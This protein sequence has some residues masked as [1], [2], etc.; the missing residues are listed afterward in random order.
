[1]WI[2]GLNAERFPPRREPDPLLPFALQRK[3]RLPGTRSAKP[4]PSTTGAG[5]RRCSGSPPRFA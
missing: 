4:T 1:M 3:H 5:S 2:A